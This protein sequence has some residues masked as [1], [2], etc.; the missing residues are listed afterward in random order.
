MMFGSVDIAMSIPIIILLM[1]IG[2]AIKHMNILS[3]VAN[4]LIPPILI[5]IGLIIAIIINWPL[6]QDNFVNVLIE[7][8]ASACIAI[9][10]HQAGKNIFINGA[11]VNAFSN[12][13]LGDS[14]ETTTEENTDNK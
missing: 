10:L 11:I 12:K 3:K 5:V 9:G 2:A 4:S 6:S 13:Y 7:G 1:L 14:S 8:L